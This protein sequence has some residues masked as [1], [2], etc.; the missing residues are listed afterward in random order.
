MNHQNK[1]TNCKSDFTSHEND[2]ARHK[3]DFINQKNNFMSHEGDL[4]NIKNYYQEFFN[5]AKKNWDLK[6]N[7]LAGQEYFFWG[8]ID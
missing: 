2:F 5:L 1:F 3:N 4:A 8:K 6:N 7:F